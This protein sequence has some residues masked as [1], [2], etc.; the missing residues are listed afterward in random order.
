MSSLFCVL[1]CVFAG[2]AYP[3]EDVFQFSEEIMAAENKPTG[4]MQIPH[5]H[6]LPVVVGSKE[7]G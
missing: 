3:G 6:L 1:L 5:I 2:R 7:H 4:E